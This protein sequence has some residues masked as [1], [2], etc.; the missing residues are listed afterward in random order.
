M[1]DLLGLLPVSKVMWL[2]ILAGLTTLAFALSAFACD[3]LGHKIISPFLAAGAWLFGAFG[4]LVWFWR[5]PLI[6]ASVD[7]EDHCHD[8]IGETENQ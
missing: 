8:E 3:R 4:V 2:L 5:L 6:M 1:D 7:G